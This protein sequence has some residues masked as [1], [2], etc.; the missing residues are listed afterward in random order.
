MAFTLEDGSGVEGAN[1]YASDA[2]VL[3]YLT[4]RGRETD[5][6]AASVG[7]RE[8]AIIKAT[9]YIEKRFRSRWIGERESDD[10]GLSWPRAAASLDGAVLTSDALPTTLVQAV[11]EY[12]L[13]ALSATLLP[14]PTVA[15]AGSSGIVQRVRRKGRP[16]RH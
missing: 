3:T 9:D 10:Q 13:R 4:D 1:A 8:I 15:A 11:A 2:Q 14:D 12:A 16:D 6:I 5:W 7:L